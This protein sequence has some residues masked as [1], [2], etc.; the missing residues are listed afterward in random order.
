MS[1]HPALRGLAKKIEA[2]AEVTGV[3][4]YHIGGRV[5]V[6]SI[7]LMMFLKPFKAA[8]AEWNNLYKLDKAARAMLE[9]VFGAV[10]G[11]F[12]ATRERLNNFCP[13]S[14]GDELVLTRMWL[15][16]QIRNPSFAA[17]LRKHGEN[18]Q[19]LLER[20]LAQP[21]LDHPGRP[22]NQDGHEHEARGKSSANPK[23]RLRTLKKI[24]RARGGIK[25]LL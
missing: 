24:L 16:H 22:H 13:I 5:S 1:V 9:D 25:I 6:E 2:H 19:L 18:A 20:V 21:A 8:A 23:I 3:G 10:E 12:P 7:A 17:H 11:L 15:I 4:Y 14:R